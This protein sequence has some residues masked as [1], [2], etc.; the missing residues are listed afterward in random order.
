MSSTIKLITWTINIF[1]LFVF[2][3]TKLDEGFNYSA[4]AWNKIYTPDKGRSRA[5]RGRGLHKGV[6]GT[7][8]IVIKVLMKL[9]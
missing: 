9:F 6:N 3:T 4:Q 5:T 2:N 7:L 1:D 8:L